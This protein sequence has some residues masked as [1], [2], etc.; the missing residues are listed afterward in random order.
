MQFKV[1]EKNVGLLQDCDQLLFSNQQISCNV[2]TAAS[3]L[4]MMFSHVKILRAAFTGYRMN[5]L[6]SIPTLLQK[7]L[8]MTLVPRDSLMK[9][10]DYVAREQMNARDGLTIAI[11]MDDLLSY[12]KAELLTDALS[13]MESLLLTPTI[14]LAS[15]QTVLSVFTAK[16]VPMPGTKR[17]WKCN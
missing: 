5:L 8:P 13:I 10:L 6:T 14:P 9:I 3:V 4:N 17:H 16:I 7:R 15:R 1:F 12:Y 2:D 11:P